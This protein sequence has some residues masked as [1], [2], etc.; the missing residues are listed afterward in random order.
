MFPNPFS[1]FLYIEFPYNADVEIIIYDLYGRRRDHFFHK[2]G[3]T[4]K[5]ETGSYEKGMYL[6]EVYDI[7]RLKKYNIK[8]L[9]R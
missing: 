4:L 5:L 1:E 7:Y 8:L 3:S 2:S 6:L 9:K